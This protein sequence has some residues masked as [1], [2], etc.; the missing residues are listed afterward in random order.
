MKK[1]LK[2]NWFYKHR[3]Y[4]S[5]V[6]FCTIFLMPHYVANAVSG[7]QISSEVQIICPGKNDVWYSGSGTVIDPKGIILTNKHVITDKDSSIIKACFI[8]FTNNVSV[9]PNFGERQNPN[10]G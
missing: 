3:Y 5:S 2:K 4:F 10:V 6:I 1:I 7:Q 9:E 8:G